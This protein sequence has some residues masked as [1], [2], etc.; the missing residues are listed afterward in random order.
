MPENNTCVCCGRIIPEGTMICLQCGYA[1]DMQTFKVENAVK[2][3]AE[4]E[5]RIRRMMDNK[6]TDFLWQYICKHKDKCPASTCCECVM[7]WL[8]KKEG[9]KDG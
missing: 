4:R 3:S 9:V 8:S 1:D 6:V 2:E 7:N 5:K